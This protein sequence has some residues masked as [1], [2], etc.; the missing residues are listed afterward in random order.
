MVIGI[1]S[2]FK[3][4][5]IEHEGYNIGKLRN[6]VRFM[7]VIEDRDY[8]S[9]GEVCPLFFDGAVGDFKEM[10]LPDDS[11]GIKKVYDYIERLEEIK[12]NKPTNAFFAF[13]NYKNKTI[14]TLQKKNI[15]STFAIQFKN[16]IKE[17]WQKL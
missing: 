1:Y 10:P 15:F 8:G 12:N 6:Y 3:F 11:V 14:K 13:S 16:K 17:L 4:K 9:A 5:K 7:E 2:P